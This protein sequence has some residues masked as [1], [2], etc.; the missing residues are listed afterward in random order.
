LSDISVRAFKVL[1]KDLPLYLFGL[2][3]GDLLAISYILPRSR[4]DPEAI[5]RA[6]D[7]GRVEEISKFIVKPNSY[8]PGA[9][10]LTIDTAKEGV[11]SWTEDDTSAMFKIQRPKA[12]IED[13]RKRIL[14]E[15]P[16][17]DEDS[18]EVE[19]EIERRLSKVATIIDGQHRLKGL[20]KAG[21][22]GVMLPVIA[23]KDADPKK[24]AKIFADINGE[25]R[26]V[27]AN[28]ILMIRY[29]IG[30]IED[31][32]EAQAT[33]IARE[34]NDRA[35][36]PFK[37]RVKVYE[38]DAKTWIPAK[39]LKESLYPI[40]GV[41][42]LQGMSADQQTTCFVS[43]FQALKEQ[44]PAAFDD[45]TRRDYILT[46]PRGIQ[47]ALGVFERVWRRCEVYEHADFSPAAILRQIQPLQ[48]MNWSKS[49]YGQ[50]KGAG[51]PILLRTKLLH[52]LPERDDRKSPEYEKVVQ[53]FQ[54]K[55]L[56]LSD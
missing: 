2:S 15:K 44:N 45:K 47:A 43:F 16:G 7:A 54:S 4:D 29:E 51:G 21:Q 8:L 23:L 42:A 3:A 27:S 5:E 40:I 13:I 6:L 17:L 56:V 37:G 32:L 33:Q 31:A 49:K 41:G 52:L 11:H 35:D 12:Q 28:S 39:T 14:E 30:A 1:H 24:A 38:A 9:I 46:Q 18:E 50:L 20:E 26:P 55:D 48:V 53:W 34:M 22:L 10:L 36:S 19:L 25:Q